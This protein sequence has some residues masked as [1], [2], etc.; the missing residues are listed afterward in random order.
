MM[1]WMVNR[2]LPSFDQTEGHL[3]PSYVNQ[4]G[5]LY[6]LVTSERR[7]RVPISAPEANVVRL[8]LSGGYH[9]LTVHEMCEWTCES[10]PQHAGS[11]YYQLNVD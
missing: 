1:S 9:D 2:S 8:D 11:H 5:K 3:E 10:S 6:P 4:L 7:V